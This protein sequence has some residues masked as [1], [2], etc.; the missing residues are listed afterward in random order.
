VLSAS[1]ALDVS[2]SS[3]VAVLDDVI[4]GAATVFFASTQGSDA[5]A[6]RVNIASAATVAGT[7]PVSLP[8]TA[9][10][11]Q[12]SALVDRVV[13][14]D[15]HVGLNAQTDRLDTDSFSMDVIVT[16]QARALCRADRRLLGPEAGP[17][18]GAGFF[19]DVSSEFVMNGGSHDHFV[20]RQLRN[21][22]RPDG[23]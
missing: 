10:R 8:V 11:A 22:Q 2:G 13:G 4:S 7:G 9:T 6:V 3:D 15:F 21:R 16:F 12:L 19:F 23:D 5:A 20:E 18:T 17:R 14:G 1:I